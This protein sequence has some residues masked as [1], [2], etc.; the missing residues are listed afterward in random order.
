MTVEFEVSWILMATKIAVFTFAAL[1]IAAII[2]TVYDL[3]GV[4][5][6]LK[7]SADVK[8]LKGFVTETIFDEFRGEIRG[9]LTDTNERLGNIERTLSTLVERQKGEKKGRRTKAD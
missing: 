4:R 5:H 9:E 1:F 2:G 7:A 8:D 3:I 6:R